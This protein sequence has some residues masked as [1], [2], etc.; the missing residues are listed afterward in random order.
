MADSMDGKRRLTRSH[1]RWLAGVCGGLADFLGWRPAV[2]RMG[3]ILGSLLSAGLGGIVT[4]TILA[5]VMPPPE[6][7]NKFRLEDFRV[8]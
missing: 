5:F 2:V 6:D 8:Q 3:W 4:Y 7:K 1:D